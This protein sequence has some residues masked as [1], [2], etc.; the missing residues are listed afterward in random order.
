[1]NSTP[2]EKAPRGRSLVALVA[3]IPAIVVVAV[4]CAAALRPSPPPRPAV[5]TR[6]TTGGVAVEMEVDPVAEDRRGQPPRAG[7]EVAFRFRIT[8]AATGAPFAKGYPVAWADPRRAGDA[9]GDAGCRARVRG[10]LEGSLFRRAEVDLNEY[11]VLVLGDDA[12]ISIVDPRFGFG[13][14]KLLAQVTLPAPA[15]D[16]ALTSDQTAL[17]VSMP[18]VGR[19]AV[20]D[21]ATWTIRRE[22][23][24]SAAPERIALQ[25]DEERL[26]VLHRASAG[27]PLATVIA[28]REERVIGRVEESGGAGGI[29]FSEES[30]FA[31][32]TRP[33]AGDVAVVDVGSLSVTRH[34][35]AGRAPTSI[36]WSPLARAAFVADA[37]GSGVAVVDAEHASPIAH[38][39][40]DA[41]LTG[42]RIAP[43]GRIGVAHSA[44]DGTMVFFDTSSNA[45]SPPARVPG[46]PDQIVFTESL[47]YVR[48]RASESVLAV[49]LARASAA[50]QAPSAAEFPAGQK[51]P[52]DAAIPDAI[53]PAPGGGA[54]LVANPA[55]RAVYYY[56]EGMAAPMGQFSTYGHAPIGVLV[57]DR[58][59]RERSPGVY[60]TRGR[61][62]T[63]GAH[64]VAF[65]LDSPRIVRCF[66]LDVAAPPRSVENAQT[67]SEL[68]D[69]DAP[70]VVGQ[71]RRVRFRLR[72]AATMEP[73]SEPRGVPVLV[74]R[75]P[76]LWQSRGIAELEGEGVYSFPLRA[77]EAGVYSIVQMPSSPGA[78]GSLPLTIR[79]VAEE[80]AVTP[81]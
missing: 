34:V 36:A 64:E 32:V 79:A 24:T 11:L 14:T 9:E 50:G 37:R 61:L 5:S 43:G 55:D 13:G 59:L 74:Y 52:G 2:P 71:E 67:V 54:V 81:R 80:A 18:E 12:T 63:A 46:G 25:P 47:A 56:K 60:E 53:V 76:G 70:L 77:P 28:T 73:R 29:A 35:P 33:S 30:R 49:P 68:V 22:I 57:L 6:I 41:P 27:A 19:V 1:M 20:I 42:I 17:F 7:D 39:D 45:L 23:E 16:W 21:P 48:R 31:F 62:A 72:D 75:S 38:L 8:D 3:A 40:V 78:M 4:L 10:L 58:S 51:A 69:A 65:V 26:W 66:A 15:A 44:E